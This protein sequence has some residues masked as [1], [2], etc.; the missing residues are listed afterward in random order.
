MSERKKTCLDAGHGGHDPGALGPDGL[1][2]SEMALDVVLRAKTILDPHMEV[3]LTRHDDTFRSLASRAVICNNQE[4]D[5]FVSV[6]F[7]SADSPN[8][9][10]REIYT[11]RGQNNSDKLA[12]RI[13]AHN[14]R[15]IPNQRTRRDTRDGDP[16]KEANYYVIR[17]ADCPAVL[18]EGEFIHTKQGSRWIKNLD[19]RQEM[20]EAIAYGIMDY[21]RIEYLKNPSSPDP[22]IPRLLTDKQRLKKLEDQME[23]VLNHCNLPTT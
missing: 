7:N 14:D 9:I 12:D 11:T 8:A 21:H 17:K 3:V 2:E 16:D 19:N 5:S 22:E 20:A 18:V 15:L 6:H 4:C 23:R 10:G 13:E 1:K